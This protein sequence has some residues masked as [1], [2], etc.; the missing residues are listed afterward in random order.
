M[1]KRWMKDSSVKAIHYMT[2][3]AMLCYSS[4]ARQGFHSVIPYPHLW[5]SMPCQHSLKSIQ[6]ICSAAVYSI[7]MG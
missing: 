6:L 1:L 7:C 2:L 4:D 5:P 3:H